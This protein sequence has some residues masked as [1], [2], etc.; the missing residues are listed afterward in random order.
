MTN[1]TEAN[2]TNLYEAAVVAN[3]YSNQ[4]LFAMYLVGFT[5]IVAVGLTHLIGA[6]KGLLATFSVGTLIASFLWLQNLIALELL[7]A[8]II[9]L[10]V[11][12][13]YNV[14]KR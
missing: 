7:T 11:S 3:N 4:W 13:M 2:M 1:I 8:Y 10:V 9:M 12:I 6:K 5:L 14:F